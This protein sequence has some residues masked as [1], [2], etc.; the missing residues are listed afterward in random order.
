MPVHGFF[1]AGLIEDI[2]RDWLAFDEPQYRARHETVVAN[3]L[4]DLA[5]TDIERG[6]GDPEFEIAFDELALARCEGGAGIKGGE[7]GCGQSGQ[8][9]EFATIHYFSV[10]QYRKSSRS[11]ARLYRVESDLTDGNGRVELVHSQ[12]QIS[13]WR[14]PTIGSRHPGPLGE[15]FTDGH[16]SIGNRRVHN[17]EYD[18][19]DARRVLDRSTPPG[20]KQRPDHIPIGWERKE[21]EMKKS[22]IG[23]AYARTSSFVALAAVLLWV[24]GTQPVAA[25]SDAGGPKME[26]VY[27]NIQV[28]KGQPAEQM[29]ITMRFF[30]AS[31]GVACTY[32]HA[33]PN[34]SS[35]GPNAKVDP[36]AG[37]TSGHVLPGWFADE[38][39]R[40]VDTP[41]K[42]VARMMIRMTAAINKENFGSRAEITCFTRHRGNVHPASNFNASL[43][44]AFSPVAA[45]SKAVSGMSADEL[46]NKFIAAIGGETA[47]QKIS[48]RMAQGTVQYGGLIA[49]RGN[50]RT[51]PPYPVEI[52]AKLPGLRA[53]ITAEGNGVVRSTNGERGWQQGRFST[54]PRHQPRDMRA[55]EHDS[56]KLEDPY[57]FAG[58]LKQL[59]TGLR[60][61]RTEEIGGKQ[62][63]VVVG[64]TQVLPEVQLFFEKDSGMLVHVATQTQGLIGRLPTLYDYSDFRT[65]DGVK[66]PFHWVSTDISEGQSYTYQLDQVRQNVPVDAVK[67]VRPSTYMAL[68]KK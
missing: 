22:L 12:G 38:P 19:D 53:L 13:P 39:A 66:V 51:P 47:I 6:F 33:E 17:H 10:I 61:A 28:F 34:D 23:M 60:V 55:N 2:H 11:S 50:G 41:R 46:V 56:F 21:A 49:E 44:S 15:D 67:F 40:E 43:V 18:E 7:S 16:D 31:L 68:F 63:Y 9:Q 65:V 30:R 26:D 14:V 36:N 1:N 62:T 59:V 42:Q 25:Q 58:E 8:L 52:S 24:A 57:F 29:L 4:D 48:T 5:R 3:G 54:D 37:K 64:H 20:T 45:D 35:T 27:K 32:C